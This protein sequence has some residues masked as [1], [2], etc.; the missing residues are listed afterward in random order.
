VTKQDIAYLILGSS[1]IAMVGM[2]GNIA[3]SYPHY[4]LRAGIVI[5]LVISI[6]VWI[7]LSSIMRLVGVMQ[8]M[9]EELTEEIMRDLY[10][11]KNR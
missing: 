4:A 3:T 2:M 7:G 10:D 5:G 1:G 8:A 11:P 9:V 6:F